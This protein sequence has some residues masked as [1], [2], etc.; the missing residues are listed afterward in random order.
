MHLICLK[1]FAHC[2]AFKIPNYLVSKQKGSVK[3]IAT[4]ASLNA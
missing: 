4:K 3:Y 2:N 1:T